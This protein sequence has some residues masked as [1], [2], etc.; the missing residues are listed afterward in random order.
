MPANSFNDRTDYGIG[1]GLRVPRYRHI[2]VKGRSWI[3]SRSSPKTSWSMEG[4]RS[5]RLTQSSSNTV[6]CSAELPL[7]WLGGQ[8]QPRTPQKLKRLV[9]PTNT[10]GSPITCAGEASMGDMLMIFYPII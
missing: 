10:P 5:R 6:S 9:K 8:T 1:I 3:G 7:L 4:V 2:L